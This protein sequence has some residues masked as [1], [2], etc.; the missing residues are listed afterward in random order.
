MK[1]VILCCVLGL[2][3]IALLGQESF[4]DAIQAARKVYYGVNSFFSFPFYSGGRFRANVVHH[5]INALYPINY[6]I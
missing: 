3:A 6:C 1:R 5:S 2:L 4:V